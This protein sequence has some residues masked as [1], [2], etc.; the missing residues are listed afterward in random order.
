MAKPTEKKIYFNFRDIELAS[1]FLDYINNKKFY[2]KVSGQLKYN[3]QLIIKLIGTPENLKIAISKLKKIYN[4]VLKQYKELQLENST[5]RI[6]KKLVDEKL[7]KSEKEELIKKQF[8]YKK[9]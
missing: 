2:A 7:R 5:E 3:G 4:I 1:F 8:F 6:T 9:F